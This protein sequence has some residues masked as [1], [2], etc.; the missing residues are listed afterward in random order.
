MNPTVVLVVAKAP[1]SGVAKT[2]LT[3]P[4]SPEQ[5]AKVA[6]ASLLD[7]LNAVH[8]IPGI[9]PVIAWTGEIERA[10]RRDAIEEAMADMDL[11]PQRGGDL[12][13]RLAAAH[14]DVA[15]RYP[16][17]PVLQIGM[18]TPQVT[19]ELLVDSAAQLRS[20]DGPEAVLGPAVDGGWWA[21]GL[22]EPRDAEVLAHVPMSRADTG[23]L[24]GTALA[25]RGLR[26]HELVEL[27]D[28]DTVLDAHR[29]AG[30]VPD[31]EFAA[32]LRASVE[33]EGAV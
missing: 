6:A 28:V 22:R 3:P 29:V 8:G 25:Q 30:S 31:S 11:I 21:L 19:S 18:D 33:P 15:E 9:Y 14:A 27:S 17:S 7:T 16:D 10:C 2:R 20:H 5:A 13:E 4:L 24:T 23:E 26:V 12:G 1:E 32:A